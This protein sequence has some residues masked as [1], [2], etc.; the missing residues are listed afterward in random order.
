[1]KRFISSMLLL[2]VVSVSLTGCAGALLGGGVGAVAGALIDNKN[3]WRGGVIGGGL[4]ALLG[5]GMEAISREA[6]RQAAMENRPVRRNLDDGYYLESRPHRVHRADP[7]A[8]VQERV[9]DRYGNLQ[10][11]EWK[12]IC[13]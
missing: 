10:R 6:A 1:M 5:G 2:L 12:T 8:R 3:P 4:G 13:P 11:E 9:F 7:C